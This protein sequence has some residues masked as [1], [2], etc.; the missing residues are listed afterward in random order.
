MIRLNTPRVPLAAPTPQYS[1]VLHNHA[2]S[3]FTYHF[4]PIGP[5][6]P[7]QCFCTRIFPN[8]SAEKTLS[9]HCLTLLL[10]QPKFTN[11]KKSLQCL[12]TRIHGKKEVA[13][14]SEK[15]KWCCNNIRVITRNEVDSIPTLDLETPIRDKSI[16]HFSKIDHLLHSLPIN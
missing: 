6:R 1:Q 5:N 2:L 12:T 9:R 7:L 14:I 10:T 4:R 15:T 8:S 13:A 16:P 11:T 3:I